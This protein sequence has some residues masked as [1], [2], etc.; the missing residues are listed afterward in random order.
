M[1]MPACT[2]VMGGANVQ[3]TQ[4][5][6]KIGTTMDVSPGFS[7]HEKTGRRWKLEVGN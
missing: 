2:H 7:P 3:H 4:Q 1:A 6:K 5:K